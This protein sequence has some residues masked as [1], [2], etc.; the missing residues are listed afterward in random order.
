M[1]V[2]YDLIL[3][4]RNE[5]ISKDVEAVLVAVHIK[6][7]RNERRGNATK[8]GSRRASDGGGRTSKYRAQRRSV[9]YVGR[10]DAIVSEVK[11]LDDKAIECTA[12]AREAHQRRCGRGCENVTNYVERKRGK[13]HGCRGED[14]K[15]DG[16]GF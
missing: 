2:G 3:L 12:G 8:E 14:A 1:T 13:R 5:M 6:I 11:L 9:R 15:G 16:R 4:I 7:S 10:Q